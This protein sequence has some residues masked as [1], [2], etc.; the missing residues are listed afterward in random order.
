MAFSRRTFLASALAAP[1]AL[2]AGRAVGEE[3]AA[4]GRAPAMRF[5]DGRFRI[6]QVT[7]LHLGY[8]C[9]DGLKRAEQ[10]LEN[11]RKLLVE[12]KPDLAIVT[13]DIVWLDA[14]AIEGGFAEAWRRVCEPFEAAGVPFAITLGNHDHER[15]VPAKAHYAEFSK[16]PLNMTRDVPELPGAG[17]CFIP[18]LGADGKEKRRI[19]LFDSHSYCRLSDNPRIHALSKV[20]SWEYDWIKPA[21]IAWYMSESEKAEAENGAP[22]PSAA[23][24]HIPTPEFWEL[25]DK[26][27]ETYKAKEGVIGIRGENPASPRVNSGLVAAAIQR[28]DLEALF[29]GHE[30]NN[31]Y[32]GEYKGVVLAYGRKTGVETYGDLPR[33]G[34]VIDF[35]EDKPGFETRIVIPGEEPLFEYAFKR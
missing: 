17:N 27:G 34:R 4:T 10:T 24:F 21:Q 9:A 5:K 16:S 23:F 11:V 28:G 2:E 32:I 19:W 7:D 26:D 13:G 22:V 29:V 3:S 15:K 14:T 30:H 25:H 31:D 20:V 33:G 12:T 8:N 1:L 35:A 6:L 18:I